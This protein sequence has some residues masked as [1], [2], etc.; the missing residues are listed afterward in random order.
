MHG[1]WTVGVV[2]EIKKTRPEGRVKIATTRNPPPLESGMN[3]QGFLDSKNVLYVHK[4][5]TRI[6]NEIRNLIKLKG[7]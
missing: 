1:K 3:Y 6:A 5:T 4:N 2:R 7:A